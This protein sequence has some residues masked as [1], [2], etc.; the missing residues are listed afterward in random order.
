MSK[1]IYVLV[2]GILGSVLERDGKDIFGLTVS[3]GLRALFT[4]GRSILDLELDPT[5]AD[6]PDDGVSATRLAAD[7]HLIPGFW[8]IDGYGKVAGYLQQRLGAVPGESYF[9][10]PY[11]WRL[12]N[13]V[14][15]TRLRD[16][17]AAW[18]AAHRARHPDAKLVLVAHSM[19]GLVSRYFLEV[20]GGWRDTRA[21]VTFGTPYRGSLNA[22]DTLA[23]GISKGFGLMDLTDLVRSLPSVHQLLPIYPCVDPGDGNVQ[24]LADTVTLIKTLDAG[25]V[26]AARAFHREIEDAVTHNGATEDYQRLHYQVHR[27]VGIDHPTSQS[28]LLTASTI[29]MLRSHGSEDHGGD[30]TVPRVSASPQEATD[31]SDAMFAGTRHASLQNADAV[32][33]QL[34]GWLTGVDLRNFR[35]GGPVRLS[36]DVGD[37]YPAGEPVTFTVTPS[38]ATGAIDYTLEWLGGPVHGAP[39]VTGTVPTGDGP[40]EVEVP[41]VPLGGYRLTLT[42][43]AEVEPVSDLLVVAPR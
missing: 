42:G 29:R 14:A 36:L 10:L 5:A 12:D 31:D 2:P 3:A 16:R 21:L 20:L 32:L 6:V 22:L 19:G 33:T 27:I 4:G 18:L 13:R 38:A 15:A 28:A 40:R 30:G 43:G 7:A 37:L 39:R 23:N 17:S 11:D 34:R 1:D 35:A 9:E 41:S 25:A 8:K 26:A 24:R